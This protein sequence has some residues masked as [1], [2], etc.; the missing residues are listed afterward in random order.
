MSIIPTIT[1]LPADS[2][3]QEYENLAAHLEKLGFITANR[4]DSLWLGRPERLAEARKA[5]PEGAA[6]LEL[7][8]PLTEDKFDKIAEAV[9]RA[10]VASSLW[11]GQNHR[12]E[13]LEFERATAGLL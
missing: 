7:L 6:T 1:I 2:E 4:S 3:R 10:L 8:G 12:N 9:T 13:I 11:H 5:I